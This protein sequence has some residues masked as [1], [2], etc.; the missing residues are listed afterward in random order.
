MEKKKEA[1][2][3]ERKEDILMGIIGLSCGII[4]LFC[5]WGLYL[6]GWLIWRLT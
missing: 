2:E 6:T 5:I 1:K 3:Q 4:G